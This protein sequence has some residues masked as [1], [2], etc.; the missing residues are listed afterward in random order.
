MY[1]YY[2]QSKNVNLCTNCNPCLL[3][4]AGVIVL[5]RSTVTYVL[6]NT[7]V[8]VVCVQSFEIV[9]EHTSSLHGVRSG[10]RTHAHK[11]TMRSGIHV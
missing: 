10:I 4:F 1:A 2:C 7:H 11:G 5:K 8:I 9:L 3:A 6:G